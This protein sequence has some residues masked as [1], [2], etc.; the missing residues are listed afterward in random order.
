MLYCG[1]ECTVCADNA[2]T[3]DL[4]AQFYMHACKHV[5]V[6]N[7]FHSGVCFCRNTLSVYECTC[8]H[9]YMQIL[10]GLFVQACL[11]MY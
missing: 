8:L 1:L 6:Q 7:E 5:N 9:S 11:R 4:D 3:V 2:D 10:E